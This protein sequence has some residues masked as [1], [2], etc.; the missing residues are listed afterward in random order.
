MAD[1]SDFL[2]I[3]GIHSIERPT[4]LD[5]GR[6]PILQGISP[7]NLRILNNA[8]R[9][10]NISKGVEILHEGDAPHDLYFIESGKLTIA[11]RVG[12]QL[13]VLGTLM[14]GSVFGE[15]GSLRQKSRYASV[16]TADPSKVIR[17][18]LVA[19]QQVLDADAGFRERIHGLLNRRL[20]DNVLSGHPVFQRLD[21]SE[22][23]MLSQDLHTH[24][25][26]RGAEIFLQGGTPRGIQMIISGEVEVRYRTAAKGDLLLEIRRDNDLIGEV[27]V[28][29][30]TSLAYSAI[31]A[32][33]A[34]L[35]TLDDK[36]MELLRSRH[37]ATA[38]LLEQFIAARSEKSVA[39]IRESQSS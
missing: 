21:S 2:D 30:G 12:G 38:Q 10:M 8:S 3:S 1:S 19:V 11:K 23:D 18:D 35:L 16:Y 14:P 22:R 25:Y 31:A 4:N 36:S 17:V 29:N 33:D 39:R 6:Y 26:E 27:A 24:F 13:K 20:I 32:S 15:Y 37:R 7:L 34:D 28:N 9:V 5:G